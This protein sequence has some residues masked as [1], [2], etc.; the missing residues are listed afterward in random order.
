MSSKGRGAHHASQL[1]G[2]VI[3]VCALVIACVNKCG[4][5]AAAPVSFIKPMARK[6][7]EFDKFNA[8]EVGGSRSKEAIY[9]IIL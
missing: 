5:S 8:I 7:R 2:A 6:R 4:C 3:S 9:I 1:A